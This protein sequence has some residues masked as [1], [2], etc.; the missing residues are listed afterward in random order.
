MKH[1]QFIIRVPVILA[2]NAWQHYNARW[3]YKPISIKSVWMKI[4]RD[5]DIE[6]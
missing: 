4:Y 1:L 3:V 5:I 2:Y 6:D